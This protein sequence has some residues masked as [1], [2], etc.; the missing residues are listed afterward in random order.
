LAGYQAKLT[1]G[2]RRGLRSPTPRRRVM[3][4]SQPLQGLTI[5]RVPNQEVKELNTQINDTLD[6]VE[7][8]LLGISGHR[9]RQSCFNDMYFFLCQIRLLLDGKNTRPRIKEPFKFDDLFPGGDVLAY[10]HQFVS[11]GKMPSDELQPEDGD[12]DSE[13]DAA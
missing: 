7:K 2:L 11:V 1:H 13:R 4:K 9:G 3:G 6:G 5:L 12:D 10:R 8:S